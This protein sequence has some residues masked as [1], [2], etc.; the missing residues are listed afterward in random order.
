MR[1]KPVEIA[2]D[3]GISDS[4]LRNWVRQADV[5]EGRSAGLVGFV[6]IPARCTRRDTCS[7]T[8]RTWNRRSRTLSTHTKSV[9]TM[10]AAW[11]WMNSD[12]DGPVRSPDRVDPCA[13]QDLP[14]RRQSGDAV[15]EAT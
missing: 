15:S 6:V 14:H 11:E 9:A 5:E 3:S 2:A 1:E 4:C 13:T 7:M 12:H 8:N 10:L